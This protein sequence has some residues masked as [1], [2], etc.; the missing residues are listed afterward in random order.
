MR[1]VDM[2]NLVAFT[3]SLVV[4]D[5]QQRKTINSTVSFEVQ[6]IFLSVLVGAQV[7][8]GSMLQISIFIHQFNRILIVKSETLH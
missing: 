7:P 6:K 5:R 3:L 4:A 2:L 8:L 1:H